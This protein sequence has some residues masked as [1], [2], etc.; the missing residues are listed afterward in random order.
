MPTLT[1]DEIIKDVH[2]IQR[3]E[4]NGDLTLYRDIGAFSF[5]AVE[6]LIAEIERLRN[7]LDERN[8]SPQTARPP[9]R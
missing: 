8:K 4:A 9:A 3:Q 1:V 7:A 5:N 6:I 2:R